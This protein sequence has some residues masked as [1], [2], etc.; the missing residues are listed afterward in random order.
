MSPAPHSLHALL[1]TAV[2][3]AAAT[4][5]YHL[6]SPSLGLLVAV[7]GSLLLCSLLY[8]I[9]RTTSR[10]DDPGLY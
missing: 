6:V 4:L 9:S 7:A 8:Q 1:L 3:F 5:L 2:D 10:R